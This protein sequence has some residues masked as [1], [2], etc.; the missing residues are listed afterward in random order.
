M[1][2]ASVTLHVMPTSIDIDLALLTKEVKA[3]IGRVYGA[4]GEIRAGEEPI[5]F[6]LRALTL[7][8]V[9]DERHGTDVIEE[10]AAQIPGVMSAKVVDF[11]R[12]IG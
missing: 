1:A 11:R 9:I 10:A 12:A 4:V 6:G 5:A 3:A 2:Y 8:F 7:T